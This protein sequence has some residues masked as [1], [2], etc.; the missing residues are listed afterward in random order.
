MRNPTSTAA[1][2]TTQSR[3]IPP[4]KARAEQYAQWNCTTCAWW[5]PRGLHALSNDGAG[6]RAVGPGT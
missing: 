1:T 5:A 2:T 3:T 6:T 4:A